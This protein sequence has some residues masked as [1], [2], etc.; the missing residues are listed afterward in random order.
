[1]KSFQLL[2][3]LVCSTVAAYCLGRVMALL[4]DVY[5]AVAQIAVNMWQRKARI[6][7]TQQT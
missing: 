1:M 3:L 7:P 6:D 2:E 4:P 5:D